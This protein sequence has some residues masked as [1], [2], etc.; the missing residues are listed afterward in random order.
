MI[1]LFHDYLIISYGSSSYT[2]KLKIS[3]ALAIIN[4]YCTGHAAQALLLQ[5]RYSLVLYGRN[6][7]LYWVSSIPYMHVTRYKSI[8]WC[9]KL[10]WTVNELKFTKVFSTKLP[11]VLIRQSFLLI[12]FQPCPGTNFILWKINKNK[13][14]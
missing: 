8:D 4:R 13:R 2:M 1:L 6:F 14:T 10:N 3:Y 12:C 9:L 11:T 5:N 7:L